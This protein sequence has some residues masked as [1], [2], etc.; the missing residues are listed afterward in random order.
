MRQATDILQFQTRGRG[1]FDITRTIE[2]WLEQQAMTA[3]LLTAFCRHTSASLLIQENASPDVRA[4]LEDFLA[5]IAPES[6]SRYRHFDEG[7]D[8]MPAHIRTV[9]TGVQ[10]SVPLIEG[11]LALG[12]WQAVYLFEH[13]RQ[14]HT[15]Q[16]A[17]HL[18][19]E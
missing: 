18:I 15:R 1:L 16:V 12:T 9:L 7:V 6:S 10:I 17:L 2:G 11:K 4:D 14:P 8:D 19:G 5:R 3:G 13:R